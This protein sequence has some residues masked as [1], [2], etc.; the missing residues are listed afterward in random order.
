[1]HRCA[2]SKVESTHRCYPPVRIPRPASDRVVD[3]CSPDKH[4]DNAGEHTASLRNSTDG[5]SYAIH[6]M[7]TTMT[8]Q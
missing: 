5:E 2:A 3:E 7:S 6:E 1:M 8:M 4:E